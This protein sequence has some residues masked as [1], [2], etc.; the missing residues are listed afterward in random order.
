M[1][2]QPVFAFDQQQFVG[3]P[4][5]RNVPKH[6][7]ARSIAQS[8]VRMEAR[9]AIQR[10]DRAGLQQPRQFSVEILDVVL[11][12][13]GPCDHSRRARRQAAEIY[14]ESMQGPPSERPLHP[15]CHERVACG[16]FGDDAEREVHPVEASR[17]T[18]RLSQ[19]VERRIQPRMWPDPEKITVETRGPHRE[20]RFYV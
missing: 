1:P 11:P 19:L 6:W 12:A 4:R 10:G 8:H 20:L 7:L 18:S 17:V 13:R 2:R 5:Q 3:I 15:P 16:T 14:W 9:F